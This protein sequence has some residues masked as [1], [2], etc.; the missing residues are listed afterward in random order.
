MSEEININKSD[1]VNQRTSVMYHLMAFGHITSWEA[2]KEYGITR[3]SSIIHGLRNE[4]YRIDSNDVSKK[5]RFGN[6]VTFT[7]YV[8]VRPIKPQQ[9]KQTNLL[10]AI[11]EAEGLNI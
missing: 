5:N 10:D 1:V 4:G 8:Y 6:S 2:I 3:L 7:K 11:D 9:Y